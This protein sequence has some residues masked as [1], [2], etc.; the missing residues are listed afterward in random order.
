MAVVALVCGT[1]LMAAP[2]RA[3][4]S[5]G[6][7]S[8]VGDCGSTR[9]IDPISLVLYGPTATDTNA[10]PRLEIAMS[11]QRDPDWF[12]QSPASG[13]PQYASSHEF[14]T[15][16]EADSMNGSGNRSHLRYNQVHHRDTKGRWETV[17]TP[18]YDLNTWC[19]HIARDF[20]YVKYYIAGA[21]SEYGYGVSYQFWGN[22][23]SLQQCDGTIDS[24][25]GQVAWINVG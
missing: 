21:M 11:A 18:H 19:G 22:T 5:S 2:A 7:Y 20:N 16:M 6:R 3:D 14:C 1:S 24:S 4:F 12:G 13:A 23:K 15:L 8:H 17:A 10:R 9:A 25:D